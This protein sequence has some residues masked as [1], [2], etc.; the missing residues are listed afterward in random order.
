M[1]NERCRDDSQRSWFVCYNVLLVCVVLAGC[2]AKQSKLS[3]AVYANNA[4]ICKNLEPLH[5]MGG[6]Y[7]DE[8]GATV[9]ESQTWFFEVSGSRERIVEFYKQ[10][11]PEATMSNEPDGDILFTTVPKG[12]E[13]GESV[14]VGVDDD[15]FRIGESCKPGK[16]KS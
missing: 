10:K 8:N 7:E 5:Q 15:G 6:H 16:I 1:S 9:S 11:F 12:A 3:G 13:D 2:A 4:P 14:W